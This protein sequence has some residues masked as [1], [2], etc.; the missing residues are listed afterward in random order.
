MTTIAFPH[1]HTRLRITARGRRVLT[2]L[3]SLPVAGAIA[4]AA[5]SGGSALAA[6]DA[7]APVGAFAEVT[8]LP[9]D[10]LW[11]IAR[12]VAPAADPRDVVDALVRLNALPSASVTA[13]QRLAIPAE[14]DASR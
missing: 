3:V 10:S 12:E 1:R 2:A 11:S 8:V 9:G 4:F 14:F 13:G 5:I 7:G 6:R